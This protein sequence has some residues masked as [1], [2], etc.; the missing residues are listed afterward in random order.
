MTHTILQFTQAP[1]AM[2]VP[3]LGSSNRPKDLLLHKHG[4][5]FVEPKVFKVAICH[6]ITGPAMGDL[7]RHNIGQGPIPGQQSW[8]N[9]SQAWILHSSVGE[10]WRHHQQIVPLP[11]IISADRNRLLEIIRGIGEFPGSGIDYFSLGPDSATGEK[12]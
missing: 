1:D 12:E 7:V 3:V 10:R 5:S 11:D 4:E 2:K 9:K 6:Q 8:S